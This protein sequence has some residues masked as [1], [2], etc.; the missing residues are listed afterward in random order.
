MH[1]I[2]IIAKQSIKK[3]YGTDHIMLNI[4]YNFREFVKRLNPDIFNLG[5]EK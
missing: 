5:R 2:I 3:N 4:L 1:L